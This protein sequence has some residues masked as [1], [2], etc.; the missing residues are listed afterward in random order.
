MVEPDIR[1]YADVSA[2][3][4]AVAR[5]IAERIAQWIKERGSCRFVLAG[6]RTPQPIYERLAQADLARTIDAVNKLVCFD[7]APVHRR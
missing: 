6:G 5:V 1:C 3:V 2:L 4:D 7:W